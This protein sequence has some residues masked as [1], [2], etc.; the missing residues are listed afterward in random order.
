METALTQTITNV[1]TDMTSWAKC[2]DIFVS[3]LNWGNIG[4]SEIATAP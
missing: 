3:A 2:M 4:Q 1:Y